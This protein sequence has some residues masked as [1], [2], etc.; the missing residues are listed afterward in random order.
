MYHTRY[1]TTDVRIAACMIL[2]YA[3][4]VE[5][6]TCE[7]TLLLGVRSLTGKRSIHVAGVQEEHYH[8]SA[9]V[10][11]YIISRKKN[12]AGQIRKIHAAPQGQPNL[13]KRSPPLTTDTGPGVPRMDCNRPKLTPLN[14]ISL[15]TIIISIRCTT[16]NKRKRE[17]FTCMKQCTKQRR[18]GLTTIFGRAFF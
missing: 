2:L 4:P 10:H 12:I 14:Q 6:M 3:I 15:D 8:R 16:K 17:T 13:P 7:V 11:T 5:L 9:Y 18:A 1:I